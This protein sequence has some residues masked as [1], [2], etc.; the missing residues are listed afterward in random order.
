VN[1]FVD[2]EKTSVLLR[3]AALELH[4]RDV[5]FGILLYRLRRRSFGG[6]LFLL[7]VLSLIPGVSIFSGLVIHLLGI[8][9]SLGF[10]APRI[11]RFV[12]EYRFK[13]ERLVAMLNSVALYI[14][15]LE[16]YIRPRLIL[17]TVWPSTLFIG[18]LILFLGALISI[19]LPFTNLLP[20]LAILVISLGLLERDG[21]V[22]IVGV[23]FS[24]IALALVSTFAD[25]ALQGLKASMTS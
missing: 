24:I 11:P 18:V 10:K 2:N 19:P 16:K 23:L 9:V 7:A 3:R 14:E 20:A 21:L 22:I 25:L 5:H 12:S 13:K 8:Q 4:G 15:R 6:L 17:F 1:N